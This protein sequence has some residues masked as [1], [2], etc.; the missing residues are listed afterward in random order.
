MIICASFVV[1]VIAVSAKTIDVVNDAMIK[2]R[3]YL[4]GGRFRAR[5]WGQFVTTQSRLQ[6]GVSVGDMIR[7]S[8]CSPMRLF[9]LGFMINGVCAARS[10]GGGAEGEVW[11]T[12]GS[13]P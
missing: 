13:R 2:R 9:L 10:D 12:M 6:Y 4:G 7:P 11:L 8:S 3:N 5:P 1:F